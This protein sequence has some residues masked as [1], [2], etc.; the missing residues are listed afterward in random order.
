MELEVGHGFDSRNWINGF[1]SS[2]ILLLYGCQRASLTSRV[3]AFT[4]LAIASCLLQRK[5]AFLYGMVLNKL[6]VPPSRLARGW[7]Q[8]NQIAC[9]P[10]IPVLSLNQ[11]HSRESL[12]RSYDYDRIAELGCVGRRE[13]P[14][15]PA[16]QRT[17]LSSLRFHRESFWW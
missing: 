12:D 4:R 17:A 16:L 10:L 7:R 14:P 6:M 13:L 8:R 3:A 15:N 1:R 9:E 2:L 5:S 11:R